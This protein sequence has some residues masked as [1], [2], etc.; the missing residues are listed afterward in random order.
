MRGYSDRVSERCETRLRCQNPQTLGHR[1]KL[2]KRARRQLFHHPPA[3]R[4]DRSLL[5]AKLMGNLLVHLAPDQQSKD[6]ALAW[7]QPAK[8]GARSVEAIEMLQGALMARYRPSDG[9]E[10]RLGRHRLGKKIFRTRLDRPNRGWDIAIAGEEYDR[11]CCTVRGE[12]I[13]QLG[14]AEPGHSYIEQDARSG[15]PGG[16]C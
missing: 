2:G 4:L 6:L 9:C 1:D 8:A 12:P 15:H 7:G 14:S 16:Y 13:L 10:K 3:V 11:W 5:G